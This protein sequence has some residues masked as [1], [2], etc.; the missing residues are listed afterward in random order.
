MTDRELIDSLRELAARTGEHAHRRVLIA[1][2]QR[3]ENYRIFA[4]VLEAAS[5]KVSGVVR[6]LLLALI[7]ELPE[8]R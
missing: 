1:A 6:D 2:A 8:G 4:R 7:L 3:L 5:E